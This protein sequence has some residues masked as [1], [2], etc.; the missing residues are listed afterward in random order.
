MNVG[1]LVPLKW[2]CG[3]GD[4]VMVGGGVAGVVW[5]RGKSHSGRGVGWVGGTLSEKNGEWLL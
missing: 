3:D 4:S 1:V 2:G 5:M